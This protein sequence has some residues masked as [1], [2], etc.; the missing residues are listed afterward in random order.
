MG[1]N[2]FRLA[3][4]GV[5]DRKRPLQFKFNDKLL[6]GYEG[7]TLASALLANGIKVTGR[8]FKYHRP[9]GIIGVGFEEAST[10]VEVDG[11][12]IGGNYLPTTLPL[13]QG[14]SARSVN[15][16]PSAEFDVGAI[17][18]FIAPFIPAGFYYKTFK[19]PNWHLYEP[20]I[21][22]AAGLASAPKSISSDKRSEARNAHADIVIVG[23]G[24]AGLTAA[25]LCGRAGAR[26]FLIDDGFEPGGSFNYSKGLSDPSALDAYLQTILSELTQLPNVVRLQRST[27]WAYREHN[28]IVALERSPEKDGIQN[29]NWKI[30]TKHTIL[31]TGATERFLV[32]PNND[33]PGIM[34]ASAAQ[35]Y[36]N[37][38][39][40]RLAKNAVIFTNND[41]AYEAALD[42]KKAGI[43]VAAII[44]SRKAISA[45]LLKRVQGIDVLLDH[46]VEDTLGWKAIERV[47]VKCKS[48]N[49]IRD[50]DCDLLCVSGGWS[51]N[52]HLHSQAR[53]SLVFDDKM[54]AFKPDKV[55]QNSISIGAASGHFGRMRAIRDG[56]DA[57][58]KLLVEL[59]LHVSDLSL[60]PIEDEPYSIEPLW[61][62]ETH[63]PRAKAFVDLQNDVT[64]NDVKLSVR[65]GY[66]AVEHLKRYTTAGM[67]FDQG[68]VGNTNVIGVLSM[69]RNMRLDE[70]GT[71][72]FR[73]PYSPVEFGAIAGSRTGSVVLPFRH[74]PLTQWHISHGAVMYEAG[75]RWRRPGYYPLGSEAFQE[76][77]NREVRA[78]RNKVGV[79][80]GAPL[81]TF[82]IS[83]TDAGK[84][85]DY[86]YTNSFSD[87]AKG[88]GRYGLMLTDDAL[89]LDDGVSFCLDDHHY[90]MSTSTGNADFVYQTM[91]KILQLDHPEWNVR[92]TNLTSQWVNATLCGPEARAL[93]SALGT[94]IDLDLKAFPFM[95]IREGHVASIPARVARVSFTGELSFE[96]N[97]RPRD[98]VKLWEQIFIVGEKFGITPVG[99]EANHVMRVEK[100]FLSLGHEADGTVDPYDLGMGW[101]VSKAKKDFV[102]KRSLM[103][104]RSKG[105]PRRELV[106][107]VPLNPLDQLPE[108]AP[109][110]PGGQRVASEGFVTACVWS[111]SLNRWVGLALL[112][113]GKTRMGQRAHDRLPDRTIEV[114]ITKPIF[115]DVDG[116]RLRS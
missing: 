28:L 16:W 98:L 83:G 75:A 74:T 115:Y 30:R 114:E 66:S 97:V 12:E 31:A 45:N 52:V 29:R 82:D 33:R 86:I 14:L 17:N 64:V 11:G 13:Y 91:E 36:V 88:M 87:L 20:M 41:T 101:V 116:G 69:L 38:Y 15:C 49:A 67:G 70:V 5:I 96:I 60:P 32:F 47:R 104:R 50:I 19:W 106:G 81:G 39:A 78:V 53:G 100:G 61:A 76:T 89:I 8:S 109:I 71:T 44:D 94:D 56:I 79:Y 108:G 99:S 55:H 43:R 111:I 1:D 65:E 110:T 22:K 72:T 63:R 105:V 46:V 73:S 58:Q 92:I 25:L 84:F 35:S 10:L 40:V 85:L 21:R 77:I 107:V 57:A 7:D 34:L 37:R 68:K 42:L 51:P 62:V 4:G 18:Q 95:A 2:A 24:L 3:S 80:D 112:E 23:A 103:L 93:L 26:V 59:G 6:Q 27:A 90:V 48:N 54:A 102:G 9:R 113:N